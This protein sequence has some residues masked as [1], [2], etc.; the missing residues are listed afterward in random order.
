MRLSV[1][2]GS[3]G[4]YFLKLSYEMTLVRE[5][6]RIGYLCKCEFGICEEMQGFFYSEVSNVTSKSRIK[7]PGKFTAEIYGMDTGIGCQVAEGNT[8]RESGMYYF[9]NG[10]YP[11]WCSGLFPPGMFCE[12]AP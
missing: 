9:S 6:A 4:F 11:V 8:V 1:G 12:P 2:R 10:I 3:K 7:I 5:P